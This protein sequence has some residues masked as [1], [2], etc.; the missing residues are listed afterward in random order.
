LGAG[1]G[2][3]GQSGLKVLHLL[4]HPQKICNPQPKQFFSLPTKILAKSFEHL[5][6]SLVL[7]VLELCLHKPHAIRLFL[8]KLLGLERLKKR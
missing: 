8:C 3:V 6:S 5:N 4:R 1:P 2:E 7:M